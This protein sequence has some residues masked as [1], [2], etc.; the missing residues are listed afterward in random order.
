VGAP[1]RGIEL[2]DGVP[3]DVLAVLRVAAVRPDDADFSLV[4]GLGRPRLQ[5]PVFEVHLKNRAT[6]WRYRRRGDGSVLSTEAQPLP[7]TYFGNAGTKRKPA[8]GAVEVE[9]DPNAPARVLR[10]VSEIFV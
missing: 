7:L 10:V 3:D 8:A 9:R 4:D 2:T 1:A 6:T 5:A